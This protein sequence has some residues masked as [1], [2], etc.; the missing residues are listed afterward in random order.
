[1]SPIDAVNIIQKFRNDLEK[2]G[3]L[4]SEIERRFGM[5]NDSERAGPLG[6]FDFGDAANQT[7]LRMMAT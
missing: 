7:Q 2:E 1:M 4:M 5:M 6:Q 3:N